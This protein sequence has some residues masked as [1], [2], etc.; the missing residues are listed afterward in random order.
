MM[1]PA[2]NHVLAVLLTNCCAADRLLLLMTNCC[3][4]DQ[5]LLLLTNGCA[6]DKLLLLLTN[7][8]PLFAPLSRVNWKLVE[9]FKTKG[10]YSLLYDTPEGKVE[11]SARCVA[12]TVPA[13]VAGDERSV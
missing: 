6:S 12:L 3:A 4:A 13:Y 2:R 1:A 5:L 8:A 11:V 7:Q 9:V 10:L